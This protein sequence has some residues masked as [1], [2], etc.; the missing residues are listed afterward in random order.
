MGMV[1]S[2]VANHSISPPKNPRR[3]SDFML[4][5]PEKKTEPILLDDPKAQTD[6]IRQ[7]IFGIPPEHK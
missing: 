4:F 6:L 2:T 1:C 5:A 7:V 3:P